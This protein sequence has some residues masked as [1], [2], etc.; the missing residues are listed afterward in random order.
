MPEQPP[1]SDLIAVCFG[2]KLSAVAGQDV[3]RSGSQREIVAEVARL[4]QERHPRWVFWSAQTGAAPL[5]RNGIHLDR[6]WDI[7]EAHRLLAGGLTADPAVAWATVCRLGTSDLPRVAGGDLFDFAA[8]DHP[9]DQGDSESPVRSD[10][11]LRPEAVAGTWQT[12]PARILAWTRVAA[13]AATRQIAALSELSN[14][15]VNTGASE[16]AAALLCVELAA[17]GLPVDRPTIERLIQESAGPRPDDDAD[18]RRIRDARDDQV[19]Q[20]APGRESSDL[21]NPLQV[22]D[23]LASV[24]VIVPDTRA[25]RLEPFRGTHPLVEALLVWRKAERIATTYGYHWLDTNIGCDDRLRGAWTACDGAAGRMTAQNGLHNLPTPLRPAVAAHPGH[26]FVRS[27]LGQIEPRVLAA[28]SG[29]VDFARAT[30][31]DDLYAPVGAALKVE[32]PVAK[33]AVLAAMYGQT[34]GNAGEAL[35]D[36]ERAYPTAMSYLRRAYDSGA[37]SRAIRTYGGRRI[38]MWANPEDAPPG[39]LQSMIASRGRFARNAVIQGAAAELFKAWAA[40]VRLTTRHLGGRIVLCLHDEL[41]VHVPTEAAEDA[42]AAV[43][44]ALIASAR[45]WTGSS[46]VRFVSDTSVISRWS[47]AKA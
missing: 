20:H 22:R 15:A 4:E 17:T 1:S 24:G 28:V 45:R 10:G 25:W 21:R 44:A 13:G 36:L 31:A 26:V 43:D 42:A 23:L 11:Y 12:S 41:L 7:A 29:D 46:A 34:S 2:A 3:C 32:R 47:E 19:L 6:C 16:S 8:E 39:A 5:V 14:R 27:D 40:T 30:Q 38:P 9:G 35:K 37:A 33:I 18:A